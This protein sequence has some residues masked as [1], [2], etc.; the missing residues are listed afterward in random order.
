MARLR[1]HTYKQ[2][3]TI[4]LQK[5]K[6]MTLEGSRTRFYAYEE[7]QTIPYGILENSRF[8][9]LPQTKVVDSSL[10]ETMPDTI[11]VVVVEANN[12][13]GLVKVQY[14]EASAL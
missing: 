11:N 8:Y 12:P 5:K 13:H 10:A 6:V 1:S 14:T 2:G 9:T 4:K 7:G 3:E